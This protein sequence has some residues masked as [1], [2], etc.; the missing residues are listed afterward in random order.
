MFV[1]HSRFKLFALF[2]CFPH[3]EETLHVKAFSVP[4]HW[5]V[6]LSRFSRSGSG[7]P[8]NLGRMCYRGGYFPKLLFSLRRSNFKAEQA[9]LAIFSSLHRIPLLTQPLPGPYGSRVWKNHFCEEKKET[10]KYAEPRTNLLK[11]VTLTQ[12][13]LPPKFFPEGTVP[14]QTSEHFIRTSRKALPV[15]GLA[16]WSSALPSPMATLCCNPPVKRYDQTTIQ[17]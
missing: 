17:G 10:S 15:V 8:R 1:C 9:L 14:P 16:L 13:P 4:S 5:C 3:I 11:T 2:L 12:V 7:L 6:N